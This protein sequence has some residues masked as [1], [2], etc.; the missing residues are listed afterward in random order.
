MNNYVN[1]ASTIAIAL[2]ISFIRTG[3]TAMHED[4]RNQVE[5]LAAY[6]GIRG[7]KPHPPDMVVYRQKVCDAVR[8][9]VELTQIELHAGTAVICVI[10]RQGV[11]TGCFVSSHEP[12]GANLEAVIEKVPLPELPDS[13]KGKEYSMSVPLTEPYALDG[14]CVDSLID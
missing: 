14:G 11:V 1:W 2:Q 4:S 7:L 9:A 12:F 5:E 6:W 13:Y 8:K 3:E 10:S